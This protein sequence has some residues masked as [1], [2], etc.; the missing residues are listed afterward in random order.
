MHASA[1]AT[2]ACLAAYRVRKPRASTASPSSPQSPKPPSFGNRGRNSYVG[3]GAF[4]EGSAQGTESCSVG[5]TIYG[6]VPGLHR[7]ATVGLREIQKAEEMN[8]DGL[9]DFSTLPVEV[10]NCP[11]LLQLAAIDAYE[12]AAKREARK[13]WTLQIEDWTR[14][15]SGASTPPLTWSPTSSI[16]EDDGPWLSQSP[17]DPMLDEEEVDLDALFEA[18]INPDAYES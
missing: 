16:S 1:D 6:E 8:E 15:S 11:T 17:W 14:S 12:A 7:W 3:A 9:V 4:V 13:V 5:R 18:Y 2:I 10:Q